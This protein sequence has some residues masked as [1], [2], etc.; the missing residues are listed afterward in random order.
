MFFAA[1]EGHVA[2]LLELIACGGLVDIR[3]DEQHSP[4]YY[5]AWEGHKAALQVLLD[6]G[7]AFGKTESH[8]RLPTVDQERPAALI[9]KTMTGSPEEEDGIPSLSLPPP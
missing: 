2:V 6:A 4:T 9:H 7:G 3:D 1:S 5:S 8:L